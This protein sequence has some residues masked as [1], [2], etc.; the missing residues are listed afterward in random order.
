VAP[1]RLRT[2]PSE[3]EWSA[4]EVPAHLRACADFRGG[5]ILTILAEDT[6]KIRAV[7]PRLWMREQT[8]Y[9]DLD[10]RRSLRTFAKQR[11]NLLG[12]LEAFAAQ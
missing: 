1:A 2:R 10:F 3:D 9:P 7:D 6:P 4:N 11:A 12:V 8:D 5:A